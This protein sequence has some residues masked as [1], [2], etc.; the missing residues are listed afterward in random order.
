MFFADG[1]I[2]NIK[3]ENKKPDAPKVIQIAQDPREKLGA[4]GYRLQVTSTPPRVLIIAPEKSGVHNGIQTFLS[5]IASGNTIPV[6]NIVDRPRYDYRGLQLDVARN[7]F[8]KATVLKV[9]EVM[10]MYKLNKLQLNLADEEG[11]RVEIP[12]IPEL[13]EVCKY[14]GLAMNI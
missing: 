11:W 5:L 8:D 10:A 14:L 7:F 4:E 6:I 2:N 9:L 13:T 12:G 1:P 3:V